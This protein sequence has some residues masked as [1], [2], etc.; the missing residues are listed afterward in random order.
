MNSHE[1]SICL[2]FSYNSLCFFS[3]YS[4]VRKRCKLLVN[5]NPVIFAELAEHPP[6]DADSACDSNEL[7]QENKLQGKVQNVGYSGANSNDGKTVILFKCFRPSCDFFNQDSS[8]FIEHLRK[9]HLDV[10]W[11]HFCESCSSVIHS[12]YNGS[13]L[14]EMHHLQAVHTN[15]V[16]AQFKKISEANPKLRPW[17]RNEL[18]V[19]QSS[20]V[21]KMLKSKNCLIATYKCME[22]SCDFVESCE[23]LFGLHLVQHEKTKGLGHTK[24]CYCVEKFEDSKSL[25]SHVKTVHANDVH[26]CSYCFYR[27]VDLFNVLTHI[28]VHHEFKKRIVIK[29]SPHNTVAES[30]LM[31]PF[32]SGHNIQQKVRPIPCLFLQCSEKFFLMC[33]YN[34]HLQ[35]HKELALFSSYCSVCKNPIS[36][37][38]LALHLEKCW[39]IGLYQCLF[40]IFGTNSESAMKIHLADFHPTMMT[41]VCHRSGVPEVS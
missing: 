3:K 35:S 2:A 17:L 18:E 34:E 32:K 6:K 37:Q 33:D 30:K 36:V 24:C 15:P 25:I 7:E 23:H 28:E 27:S 4:I 41:H 11:N 26:Q 19:T 14:D 38:N 21:E 40:C 5:Q 13:I 16:S 1:S 39:K 10:V 8:L 20:K 31:G 29:C 12:R 9:F 22:R